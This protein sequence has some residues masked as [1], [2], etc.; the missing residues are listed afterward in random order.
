MTSRNRLPGYGRPAGPVALVAVV[1]A[2]VVAGTVLAVRR[3][4]GA[5]PVLGAILSGAAVAGVLI[6][7]VTV[8]S[9]GRAAREQAVQNL[10]AARRAEAVA[11]DLRD[12]VLRLQSD[13]AR[14]AARVEATR[15][16]TREETS[17]DERPR[18]AAGS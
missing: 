12:E 9:C 5:V 8:R 15:R 1:A 10:A 18:S 11:A 3:D 7:L 6:V 17:D 2:L 14:L 16:R 13:L 4:P